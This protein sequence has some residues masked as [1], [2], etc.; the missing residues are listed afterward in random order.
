MTGP[1]VP[2]PSITCPVCGA[3]SYNPNDIRHGYC[4]RCHAFTAPESPAVTE[5]RAWVNRIN[6][7]VDAITDEEIEQRWQQI[8]YPAEVPPDPYPNSG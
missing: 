6:Q 1:E 2:Q 4:G 7:A 5:L 8:L 3:T